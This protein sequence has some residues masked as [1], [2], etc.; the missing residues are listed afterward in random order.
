MIRS[1]IT[2]FLFSRRRSCA[3]VQT[4][5]LEERANGI[6]REQVGRLRAQLADAARWNNQCAVRMAMILEENG[7][8]RCE[9]ARSALQAHAEIAGLWKEINEARS[10]CVEAKGQ[11]E[12]ERQ[13]RRALEAQLNTGGPVS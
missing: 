6:L 1:L 2:G 4:L 9:A 12:V 8:L 10:L 7:R 11:L 3:D 13:R 5:S